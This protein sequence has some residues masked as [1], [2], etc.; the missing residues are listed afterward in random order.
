MI[1]SFFV[2]S[3]VVIF[4]VFVV[5]NSIILE[6]IGGMLA[7]FEHRQN[8]IECFIKSVVAMTS[9]KLLN[10]LLRIRN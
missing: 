3:G 8:S 9:W 5:T 7:V 10:L 1:V 2:Q 4:V 6:S